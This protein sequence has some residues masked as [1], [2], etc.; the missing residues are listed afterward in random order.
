MCRLPKVLLVAPESKHGELRKALS[1]LSYDIVGAVTSGDDAG[2]VPA[3]VALVWEPDPD[4]VEALRDRGLKVVALGGS[5]T[6]A[7]MELATDDVRAFRDRFW[8]LFRP[9]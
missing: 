8:E 2:E 7:D 3:D 6:G 9:T 5:D 4:A 1:S